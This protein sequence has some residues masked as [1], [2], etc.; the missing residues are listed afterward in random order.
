MAPKSQKPKKPAPKAPKIPNL[1]KWANVKVYEIKFN[2]LLFPILF[3]IGIFAVGY[4]YRGY[5]ATEKIIQNKEIGLNQIVENYGSGVYEE[6]VIQGTTLEARMRP[7]E[8]VVDGQIVTERKVDITLV[9]E[10]LEITD[11]GLANPENPTKVTIKEQS[12]TSLLADSLLSILGTII[13]IVF[14]FFMMTRM[15]GGGMGSPMAFIKSRA[16]MYDPEVDEQV[17]FADV[18][19]AEE[20][21]SDL[22]EIVDFLK[23][24]QK[25]KDL[26]AKIPRGILL[27]WPPGTGKTLLARAVAGEAGVPFFS[28]SGSEFVEMFVGVGAARVRDLFKDA[29]ENAPSIIFIDEIDAI[30]KKRSPGIGGGHDEREQTL[31]QILTEMDGFDNETNVI[32]MAATNR[33]DVLDKA[34]LRPGRFDRKVTINLPTLEDR[35][36][37]LEVH[38]KGKPFAPDVNWDKI[39]SITVGFSGAE[40][41]NLLNESAILAGKNSAKSITQAMIQQSIEKVVMGNEKKSLRMTE[42]EKKLTAIHEIGHAIV[43]KMLAHTDP[44]H[45]ISILP[46]GWAGG[47]TWFLPEKDR[48]YT[49]KAK[50]LDELATLYGGRV[51]EEV[52]FGSEYITTGASSDIERATEIARA[53]VMRFGFDPEIGP[54]NLAPDMSEGNFLGGQGGNKVISDKTQD[55]IDSKVRALLL[56]AYALAKQIITTNKSLHEKLANTLL[57][58]EEMLQDE[59]DAFFTDVPGVPQKVAM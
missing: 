15:G 9:P 17:T 39:A 29:R 8:N 42:H 26:G 19:G 28:I 31:N 40:L 49:S 37:I 1:P 23:S 27:Q 52:F 5:T 41:G 20:E 21:K 25:Y 54:E 51:A 6:I 53:M 32:I 48:T 11:I 47:V 38:M 10:N 12:W 55:L 34:L 50:Y 24:P 22:I 57:E 33:A 30:G 58:R 59:F 16:R 7:T 35:K 4:I 14:L 43:G 13:F 46:R 56:D 18:A 45:K 36:K 44:V 3:F 2:T